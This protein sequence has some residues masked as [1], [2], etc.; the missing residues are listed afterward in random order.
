MKKDSNLSRYYSLRCPRPLSKSAVQDLCPRILTSRVTCSP[1]V[2]AGLVRARIG[3][4]GA[5]ILLHKFLI[6]SFLKYDRKATSHKT[7]PSLSPWMPWMGGEMRTPGV[8]IFNFQSSISN[9]LRFIP[10]HVRFIP[11]NPMFQQRNPDKSLQK[12]CFVL[13]LQINMLGISYK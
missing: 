13:S 10:F 11:Q 2:G 7:H 1:S 3:G 12:N 4:Q 5:L 6:C 9:L 8:A